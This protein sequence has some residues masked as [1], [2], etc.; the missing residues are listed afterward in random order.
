MLRADPEVEWTKFNKEWCF[1]SRKHQKCLKDKD[2][3]V[4]Y[5]EAC[6]QREAEERRQ[7]FKSC[8]KTNTIR[9]GCQTEKQEDKNDI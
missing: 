9:G 4:K 3:T 5:D 6:L 8:L 2:G 7:E 1:L